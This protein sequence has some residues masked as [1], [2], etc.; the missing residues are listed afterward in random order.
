MPRSTSLAAA[1]VAGTTLE[2][3]AL[4]ALAAMAAVAAVAVVVAPLV[5][6]AE[7]AAQDTAW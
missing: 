6:L 4:V 2:L 7:T 5:V 3:E 1:V